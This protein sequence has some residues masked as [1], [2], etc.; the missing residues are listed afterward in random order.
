MSKTNPGGTILNEEP[1]EQDARRE[2]NNNDV[3]QV[4]GRRFLFTQGASLLA[5]PRFPPAAARSALP[6]SSDAVYLPRSLAELVQEVLTDVTQRIVLPGAEPTMKLPAKSVLK[7]D[8]PKA[9]GNT[10]KQ[11][12]ARATS[13]NPLD[14]L[15]SPVPRA[16][17]A[18]SS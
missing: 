3:I 14:F 15:S 10:P 4:C 18:S 17:R 12:K 9:G 16:C 11:Q 5:R 13:P 7:A 8:T 2:L 6:L 1:L